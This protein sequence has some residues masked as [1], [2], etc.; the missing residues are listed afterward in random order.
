MPDFTTPLGKRIK[1]QLKQEQVIW[2]TTID[3]HN[4]PQP[5][6]VW[7]HW[8]GETVLV[9]SQ[10]HAAKVKHVKR[11]ARVSLNFNSD[12]L[13]DQVSVLIGEAKIAA[14][15]ID[16]KRVQAYLR[17]YRSGIKNLNSTAKK[18]LA[19]YNIPIVITAEAMRGF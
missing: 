18:F 2:L 13:A 9:F 16:P 3:S 12:P 6:P 7:F 4:T 15:P 19:E 11:N 14:D 17:K 10:P 5:R 8:D 1:R